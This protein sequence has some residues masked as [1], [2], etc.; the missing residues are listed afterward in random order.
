MKKLLSRNKVRLALDGRTSTHKLDTTL[1]IAYYMDRNSA[2]QEVQLAFDEVDRQFF[3]FFKSQL[4]MIGQGP[5]Y[6]N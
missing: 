3:S 5:T 2:L 4:R 6:R 1:V